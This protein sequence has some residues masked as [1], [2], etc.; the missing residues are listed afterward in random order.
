[1]EGK[2]KV[3]ITAAAV[4]AISVVGY[5]KIS[6]KLSKDPVITGLQAEFVGEVVPGQE[7]SKNMF[8]VKGVTAS[9][10]LVPLKNFSSE[11]TM[12]A[13]NGETCEVVITSQGYEST[14]IVPITRTPIFEQNIGYPNEEDATVTCYENGDLEFSGS[15]DI[16]NFTNA[17][18]WA[19]MEYSHVYIEES[20]NIENMDN[21]FYGNTN[22]VYC[23]SLPKTLKTMKSTFAGCEA[24]EKTP[25]YFQCSGLKIMDYAFSGCTGLKEI[26]IIPVN[27][28]TAKYTFENCTALQ[29]PVDLSKTSALQSISGIHNGCTN[30]RNATEI[31][32]TVTNMDYAFKDCI[33]IK[34]AVKFPEAIQSAAS[35]YEGDTALVTGATIPESI[36]NFSNCYGGCASLCG[37]LEINSDAA[38]Y[39][40]CL[41]GATT[42]GDKLT[43][44]GN[45]G[46]LLA[47]Q[48]DAGNGSIT[49]AD[50]EAA[51]QQ[52]ERMT[53]EQEE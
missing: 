33:N 47:I 8:V 5:G 53:R 38:E 46:N 4:I 52:N 1:M 24:L 35:T 17:L 18:P 34:E 36:I 32:E 12:A 41:S 27:V 45:S 29:T 51:A 3:I 21:W 23:D 40:G 49:L 11:T 42:N 13:T 37:N 39:G 44:S 28:T 19:D 9:G 20:L 7:L 22:L 6:E 15:G 14:A 43:I 31:P 48:K 30:L 2:T 16:T 50:P 26:D 25:D 10:Q